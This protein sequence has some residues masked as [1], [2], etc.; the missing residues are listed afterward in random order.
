MTTEKDPG[1]RALA[2]LV[3]EARGEAPPPLDWA[4]VEGA[5]LAR[6]A[7]EPLHRG[8]PLSRAAGPWLA[9]ALA[10]AMASVFALS[11]GTRGPAPGAE[12]SAQAPSVSAATPALSIG[13]RIEAGAQ[14]RTV[15]HPGHAT[16]TLEPGGSARVVALGEL[17]ALELE[18]GAISA[19]VVKSQRTE[20]FVIRAEGA[21][22]AVRGTVFR[23]ERTRESVHVQVSEGLLAIG[24]VDGL[25]FELPAPG[26]ATVSL[27]G[28][29]LERAGAEGP[30]PEPA[31]L[32]REKA[33]S[34]GSGAAAPSAV[35]ATA[36]VEDV[37][38]AVRACVDDHTVARGDLRIS[39]SARL[40]MRVEPSGTLG[41]TVFAPPLAPSVGRCVDAAV[42]RMRFGVTAQGFEVIRTIE[43]AL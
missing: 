23:V 25:P 21:R 41:S 29:R 26:E 35:G 5:L 31:Q 34:P 17:I 37:I 36:T 3:A 24:P 9:V 1:S 32:A 14:G 33:P 16:W 19:R 39:I 2:A 12:T 40:A 27:S 8:A 6:R 7:R 38:Q 13:A 42:A 4:Q 28:Q 30:H 22:V 11:L 20:S 15:E 43:L 10:A 18:R